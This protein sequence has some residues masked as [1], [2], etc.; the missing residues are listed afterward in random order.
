MKRLSPAARRLVLA[1][2]VTTSVGFLGAVAT[3]LALAI[4][5]LFSADPQMVRAAYP[6]MELVAWVV[7]LPLCLGSLLTGVV[8]SLGTAWGLFQHYWV[9]AKLAINVFATAILLVYMRTLGALADAA[10]VA[11]D[12]G[13]VRSASPVLH[14]SLALLLLL[15]ATVLSIYKPK[16]RLRAGRDASADDGRAGAARRWPWAVAGG[17]LLLLLAAF[18]VMHVGGGHGPGQH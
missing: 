11:G 7:V 4:A 16:G 2:H 18:L 12:V 17:A 15:I 1:A 14:A 13:E 9:A 10:A 3:V 6:A 5:G 8:Q